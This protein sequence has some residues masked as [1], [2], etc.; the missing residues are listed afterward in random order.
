MLEKEIGWNFDNTYAKLPSYMLTKIN[1]T[2]VKN[3]VTV[4]FNHS[5]SKEKK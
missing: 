3:P 5:L 2:P 4:I 1:P